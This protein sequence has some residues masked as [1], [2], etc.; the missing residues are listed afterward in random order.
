M[1]SP[2]ESVSEDT[3]AGKLAAKVEQE[4]GS[5]AAAEA[6]RT[7]VFVAICYSVC[8]LIWGTTWYAMR[9]SV[10]PVTGYPPNF[11]G[12]IRFVLALAFYI[13]LWFLFKKRIPKPSKSE[14]AWLMLSGFL[15]GMY[16]C[17]IYSA[18]VSISGGLA[19]VIMATSPLMVALI[20]VCGGLEKV[21]R[22]T[23][24][25]FIFCLMGVVLVCQDRMHASSDQAWGIGLAL[26]AAFFTSL[27]N[28]TLKGRSTHMHP[29]A[30][31]TIFLFATDIPVWVGSFLCGEKWVFWPLPMAAFLS[32]LYM[33]V[34]SSVL[35][36]TLY[37]YMIRHMSLMAIST[38]QFVLPVLALLVDMLF[39]RG[40]T[41]SPQSWT[42]IA[43]VLGGVMFSVRRK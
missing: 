39:E 34:M 42:G 27:S 22:R 40:V 41:L 30:S 15:N 21:H 10:A 5:S 13:P 1:A 26:V 17:F 8:C 6:K 35:A 9:I 43:I 3:D 20:A 29:I 7:R 18:E 28:I 2:D 11:A 32:V 37:L 16:Q 25:S 4:A 38:L 31:A 19:S 36:F 24:F 12:A 14:I 23:I 33:A